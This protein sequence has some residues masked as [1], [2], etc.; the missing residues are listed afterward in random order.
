MFEIDTSWFQVEIAPWLIVILSLCAIAF[1][2]FAINRIIR[3][4]R[5]QAS[6][7][8]EELIGKIAVVKVALEPEGTVF[9]KGERWAAISEKGRVE[10]EEEVIITKVDG[11]KLYVTKKE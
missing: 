2:V 5:R 7:G 9:F 3:A 10:P 1:L 4:H 11:L 8:K 6:V